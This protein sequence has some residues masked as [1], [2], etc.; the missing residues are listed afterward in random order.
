MAMHVQSSFQ[1]YKSPR[2][3]LT[4]WDSY[5][6]T[7]LKHS[8]QTAYVCTLTTLYTQVWIKLRRFP[9]SNKEQMTGR[10]VTRMHTPPRIRR[11]S[12]VWKPAIS[13]G[14]HSPKSSHHIYCFPVQSSAYCI[15]F[16]S[17]NLW[18][19]IICSQPR[20]LIKATDSPIESFLCKYAGEWENDKFPVLFNNVFNLFR[21]IRMPVSGTATLGL[22][23]SWPLTQSLHH[24]TVFQFSSFQQASPNMP[25]S[26]PQQLSDD[27]RLVLQDWSCTIAPLSAV[28]SLRQ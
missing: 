3:V 28:N 20:P 25:S 19:R 7:K 10:R 23:W 2:N 17:R 21:D 15:A 5:C 24:C 26:A 18:H 14:S 1:V 16:P 27:Q 4:I 6:S 11:K 8:T 12:L 13:A 22:C 9:N